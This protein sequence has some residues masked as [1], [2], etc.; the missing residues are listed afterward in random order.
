MQPDYIV[1]SEINQR[2]NNEDS[3]QI[4]SLIPGLTSS[5]IVILAIADGMGGLAH[6]EKVSQE[7]L[8]KIGLSLFE[9][10]VID[11][12]INCL[13]KASRIDTKIFSQ[14]LINS[15]AKANTHIRRI[16]EV[17]KWGNAGSTIV[18]AAI[19]A[20][21]AIVANLGDSPL[22]HY[23]ISSGKLTQITE[24]HTVAGVLFRMGM[25]TPQ[26]MRYHE[27][28]NQLEFYIGAYN[29]PKN[30]PLYK[31]NLADGDL[32]MLCSD[33]VNGNLLHKEIADIIADSVENLDRIANNLI[34]AANAAGS[35]DNQ[36][37]ILWRFHGGEKVGERSFPQE[38]L[39][40][41]Q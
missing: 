9:E 39:S 13:E 27:G 29:L 32:L 8:K 31:L 10:L 17:N 26:M 6:G 4:F 40:V 25:I 19:L 37:L 36:T 7:A 34:I 14:A 16:V 20:D 22:F 35:T 2:A 21:Q 41:E 11:R 1:R 12:S 3:F 38:S 5:P 33:G 23:Q 24:D 18:I 30:L 28:R 15:I